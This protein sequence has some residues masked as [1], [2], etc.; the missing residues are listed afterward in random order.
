[1]DTTNERII[2][3]LDEAGNPVRFE[4]Y[5]M[6][7]FEGKQ[8]AMLLPLGEDETEGSYRRRR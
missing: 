4:L 5:N 8:Y 1:M 7:E 2:E 3:T 6:L